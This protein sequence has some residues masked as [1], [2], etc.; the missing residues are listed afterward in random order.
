MRLTIVIWDSLYPCVT[1]TA[2]DSMFETSVFSEREVDSDPDRLQRLKDSMMG[3][4]LLLLH[5]TTHSFWEDLVGF[6]KG[7]EDKR[8]ICFGQDPAFWSLSN[9]DPEIVSKTYAYDQNADS[10]NQYK[11]TIHLFFP[12]SF[13]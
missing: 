5:R 2:K 6:V 12:P 11:N 10:D 13:W 9:V 7:L 1:S 8:I 3:S 4:D